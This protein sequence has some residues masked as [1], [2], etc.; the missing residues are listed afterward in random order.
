M[1]LRIKLLVSLSPLVVSLAI[2]SVLS[3]HT[4]SDL[5]IQSNLILKDNYRSV[6][7]VQRMKESIER[8][9]SACLFIIAGRRDE[10]EKI[11]SNH[12]SL[13]NREL[14]IQRGNITESGEKEATGRLEALWTRYQKELDR[15][16]S[17]SG[18]ERLKTEYFEFLEPVFQ[19][20]KE[21]ADSILLMN[22][23]AMVLKSDRV[24][25]LSERMK[26]LILGAA[27]GAFLAGLLLSMALIRKF[28]HPLNRERGSSRVHYPPGG[29]AP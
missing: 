6:L 24:Q 13:F 7:A 5:G 26:T 11:I 12:R 1:T 4:V 19:L 14:Q 10:G 3:I 17:L 29:E 18:A 22:Q 9:D 27:V 2:F 21:A 25:R 23:D 28:L 20:V 16:L 8:M 15:F